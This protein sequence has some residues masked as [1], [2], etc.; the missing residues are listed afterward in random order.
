MLLKLKEKIS[1][2]PATGWLGTG[3]TARRDFGHCL[4]QLESG[5]LLFV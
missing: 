1:L 3:D 2:L 5:C 4:D